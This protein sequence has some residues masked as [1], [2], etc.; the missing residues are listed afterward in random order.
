MR[1]PHG[2]DRVVEGGVKV[3]VFVPEHVDGV[4][5]HIHGGGWV[6]G[7]ADGQDERLWRLAEEARP[8][9]VSVEYRLAPEHPFLTGPDD[10]EAAARWLVKNAA[11]EFGTE[12]LLIGGESAGAHLS[13]LHTPP[14]RTR[15]HRRTA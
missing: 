5:L 14:L 10:C 7:S 8:T 2:R 13:V 9:V 12:R 11:A 6:F 4:Y 1:L 15:R 3:R